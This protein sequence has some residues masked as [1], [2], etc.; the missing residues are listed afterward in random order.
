MK[1]R[2]LLAA[3]LALPSLAPAAEPKPE[4][5]A[6]F[7]REVLPVLTKAGCNQGACHGASLGRGGFRLSLFGF[8]PLFDYSQIVQSAEGR[9]VVPSDPERSILLLKP[10]LQMEHGGGERLTTH[11]RAYELLRSWLEDG[12]PEPRSGDP[13]AQSLEVWPPLR[14]LVPGEQ[15]QILVRARWNDGKQED[16]TATAQ[17][18]SLNDSIALVTPE[19]LVT[20]LGVGETY[21]MV[22]FG[23]QAA[24]VQ[25]TLPYDRV[26]E[27]D[28]LSGTGF[29]R[30]NFIDDKLLTK[31]RDLG[32]TPS[33]L[34]DDATFFRRI[35]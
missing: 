9:R 29:S 7:V 15:Q 16:V 1:P 17:Y 8:D 11:S 27:A 24:V 23:G 26:T 2:C 21:V 35:H 14:M 13:A 20:G 12:A 19:G 25:I 22:R 4:P 5:R 31:W 34:A 18:D 30:Q 32:L 10:S 28:I 3:L 33:S 6:S